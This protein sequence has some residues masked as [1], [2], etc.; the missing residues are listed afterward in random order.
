[1]RH[2]SFGT[3]VYLPF[4]QIILTALLVITSA[5]GQTV[6]TIHNFGANEQS[7]VP[8]EFWR[9]LLADNQGNLYGTTFF[10]GSSS[11]GTVFELSPPA[12]SGGSWTETVLHTFVGGSND[13]ANPGGKLV[14]DSAGNL[15]GATYSGGQRGVGTVY[16]LTP[17]STSRGSWTENVLYQFTGPGGLNP[18]SGLLLDALGNLYGSTEGGGSCNNAGIIFELSPP[19]V[20]GAA[21]TETIL[22]NFRGGCHGNV[23][24][25]V[26]VGDL[27]FSKSGAIL[28]ATFWGGT[29][30]IG[31]VFE[32]TPPP[33][34][35]TQWGGRI[36]YSFEGPTDGYHPLGGVITDH[37]GNLYGTTQNGG[38]SS[39]C[40]SFEGCG[41]VF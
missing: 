11:L 23:D 8:I 3:R 36:I 39:A 28:G 37:A 33:A 14:V 18:G 29:L 9:E 19:S 21:W 35:Q 7:Q 17:P 13:G 26:P 24:G 32:I 5:F 10:G 15:Y 4:I 30:G 20:S 22:H 34:G 12:V 6:T 2:H 40:P 31:T 38:T 27:T 16:E 41:T 25:S 1:M